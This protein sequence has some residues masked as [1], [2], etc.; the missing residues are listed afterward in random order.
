MCVHSTKGLQRVLRKRL[1]TIQRWRQVTVY[2]YDDKRLPWYIEA[3]EGMFY[4]VWDKPK[5]RN[6]H[7]D[8]YKECP[9]DDLD[10]IVERNR[11]RLY[12]KVKSYR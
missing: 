2:R 8:E 12:N 5:R 7:P 4:I 1:E 10:I 11:T 3:N 9:L 6:V